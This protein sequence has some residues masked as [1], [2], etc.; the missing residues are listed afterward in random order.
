M[1]GHN[2]T[3]M[4]MYADAYHVVSITFSC[5]SNDTVLGRYQITKSLKNEISLLSDRNELRTL[6]Q[7]T[8][9]AV[10]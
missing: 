1:S 4:I 5:G 3:Y 6:P 8:Q 2:S 9:Q 10:C 7:Y